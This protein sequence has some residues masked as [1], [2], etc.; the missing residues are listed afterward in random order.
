MG[1]TSLSENFRGRVIA[2]G[3]KTVTYDEIAAL[4]LSHVKFLNDQLEA[5]KG[6]FRVSFPDRN[7]PE[8]FYLPIVEASNLAEL[9]HAG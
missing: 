2:I 1:T 4:G 6:G 9:I 7:E 5:G 3:E 8:T